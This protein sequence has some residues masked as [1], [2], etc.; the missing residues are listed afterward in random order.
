MICELLFGLSVLLLVV[1]LSVLQW[2][3]I[4]FPGCRKRLVL[5]SLR[6]ATP[7]QSTLLSSQPTL[8]WV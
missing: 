1:V 4:Y 7:E 5:P 2:I 3:N 8:L 6:K